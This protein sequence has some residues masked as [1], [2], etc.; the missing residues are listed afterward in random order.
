M[1]DQVAEFF[2]T[3]ERPRRKLGLEEL[4]EILAVTSESR[5]LGERLQTTIG[6]C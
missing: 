3:T 1:Y 2:A 5:G 6:K 4:K